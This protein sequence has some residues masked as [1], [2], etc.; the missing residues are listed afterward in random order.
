VVIP[1]STFGS[2]KQN[3]PTQLGAY[4]A[5]RVRYSPLNKMIIS[6]RI[7]G[8]PANLLV[9]TGASHVM[10]DADAAASFGIR[11]SQSGLGYTQFAQINGQEL[12]VGFAQSL[13]A[14]NM[15]FGSVLV[16]LR[17]SNRWNGRSAHVDGL[18]GLD[19][20]RR[21]KAV[22]N[23]RTKLIFFKIDPARQANLGAVALSEK[24]TR[25]PLRQGQNGALTAPCSIRGQPARL[26]VDTGAFVTTFTEPVL[27]SLGIG[28]QPTHLSAD[29]PGGTKRNVNAAQ[30]N[31]LMIGAFKV[32]PGKFG[33]AALPN[34]APRQGNS[35]MFGILGMDTLYN[36]RA[37]IDL[38]SMNLFL[39]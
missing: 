18:L 12:P 34:F 1:P 15:S 10:L 36:C 16:T 5:V 25:V 23:C 6:V 37:I 17:N 11:P 9:D 4:K 39:K 27:K 7:N 3:R 33:V 8:Q 26:L 20:L 13:S 32:P 21:H 2:V 14:G 35:R 38:G 24:F 22:I 19:I 29:F 31:D 30:I 28:L